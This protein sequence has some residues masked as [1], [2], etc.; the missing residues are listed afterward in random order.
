MDEVFR[1]NYQRTHKIQQQKKLINPQK[2][3]KN[4][5]QN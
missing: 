3:Q 5:A 2:H 1:H 4:A